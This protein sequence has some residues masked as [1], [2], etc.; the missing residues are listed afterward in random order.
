MCESQTYIVMHGEEMKIIIQVYKLSVP[1]NVTSC[2]HYKIDPVDILESRHI[3]IHTV[4]THTYIMTVYM[5]V[6]DVT[7]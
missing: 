7:S 2:M 1:T 5:Y 6:S 3:C 4:C